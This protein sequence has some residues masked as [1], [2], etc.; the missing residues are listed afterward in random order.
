M[1]LDSYNNNELYHVN[2]PPAQNRRRI[3]DLELI[4]GSGVAALGLGDCASTRRPTWHETKQELLLA[5]AHNHLHAGGVRG[6]PEYGPLLRVSAGAVPHLLDVPGGLGDKAAVR[7]VEQHPN[8]PLAE[9]VCARH[10]D[11]LLHWEAGPRQDARRRALSPGPDGVAQV[12]Q[13]HY[14]SALDYGIPAV[15]DVA[16]EGLHE[17]PVQCVWLDL[18]DGAA[19]CGPGVLHALQP[20]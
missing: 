9:L 8:N 13:L 2:Q 19:D 17:V 10:H 14:L 3:G 11:V 12:S 7:E 5:D 16:R 4:F 20:V 15:R 6:G 18:H 1:Y